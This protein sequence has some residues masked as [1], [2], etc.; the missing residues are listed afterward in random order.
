MSSNATGGPRTIVT[1]TVLSGKYE[2]LNLIG[3]GGMASVYEARE[4][5]FDIERTVAVKIVPPELLGSDPQLEK[6]FR[7][8]I[9][10]LARM[11]HP[12]IVPI[13]NVGR[14]GS[15]LYFVMKVIRGKTL[16]DLLKSEGPLPEGKIRELGAQ[17]AGA[18]A[19]IHAAG[20]VHRDVKSNNIMIDSSGQAMLMD[21]GIA[22]SDQAHT[23]LTGTGELVG[24]GPYISPEQWSGNFDLRSDIYSFGVV[25]FEIATGQP[26]YVADNIPKLMNQILNQPAPAVRKK[27]DDLS[28]SLC[29]AIHLCLRKNPDERFQTMVELQEALSGRKAPKIELAIEKTSAAIPLENE[30]DSSDSRS[31]TDTLKRLEKAKQNS[32]DDPI[33]EHLEQEYRQL[34]QEERMV[35]DRIRELTRHEEH[36]EAVSIAQEFLSRFNSTKVRDD[37]TRIRAYLSKTDELVSKAEALKAKGRLSEAKPFYEQALQRDPRNDRIRALLSTLGDIEGIEIKRGKPKRSR[38]LL[39]VGIGVAVLVAAFF[40]IPELF[41]GPASRANEKI[42]DLALRVGLVDGPVYFNAFDSYTRAKGH[43]GVTEDSSEL[44]EKLE[45]LVDSILAIGDKAMESEKHQEALNAY[46]RSLKLRP[47][48]ND[49]LKRIEEVRQRIEKLN[50]DK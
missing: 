17:V 19:H 26:P 48:D 46:T 33:V 9:K 13:Y 6:R 39:R 16:K 5:D 8:E 38:S 18:L 7:E 45:D 32:P 36:S 11:D 22:F 42:G 35:L 30:N 27:R 41:P 24:T 15:I 10:I 2:I 21:F 29:E 31:V 12:N 14:D 3:R 20:A 25:L 40:L 4:I 37:L 28:E 47:L 50:S 44:D 43:L 49:I 34:A 1:G 23:R